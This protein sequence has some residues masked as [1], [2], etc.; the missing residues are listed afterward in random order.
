MTSKNKSYIQSFF[1][2]N[3]VFLEDKSSTSA[4]CSDQKFIPLWM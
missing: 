4:A 2:E 1:K 3:L